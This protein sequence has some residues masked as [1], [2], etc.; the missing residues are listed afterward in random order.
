MTDIP[1][2]AGILAQEV[3]VWHSQLPC[4]YHGNTPPLGIFVIGDLIV[5]EVHKE[6]VTI[7]TDVSERVLLDD[8]V[9]QHNIR[10]ILQMKP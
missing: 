7:M 10:N 8:L 4:T 2:L 3:L 6:C 5:G 1:E 9:Q